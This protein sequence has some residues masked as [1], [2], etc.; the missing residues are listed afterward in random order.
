MLKHLRKEKNRLRM[1]RKEMR[2]QFEL[3]QQRKRNLSKSFF[4]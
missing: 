2:K 1:E 4:F 3:L